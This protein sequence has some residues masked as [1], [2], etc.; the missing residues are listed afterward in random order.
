VTISSTE[1]GLAQRRLDRVDVVEVALNLEEI[2]LV[3][4]LSAIGCRDF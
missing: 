1:I 3:V 2:G 4:S